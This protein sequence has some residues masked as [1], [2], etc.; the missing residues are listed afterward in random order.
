MR[1]TLPTKIFAPISRAFT[2]WAAMAWADGKLA[3]YL[4]ARWRN[5]SLRAIADDM[6]ADK[7]WRKALKANPLMKGRRKATMTK[8]TT[9]TTTPMAGMP[10]AAMPA[11]T[12]MLTLAAMLSLVA[13]QG[14]GGADDELLLH[15]RAAE[16]ALYGVADSLAAEANKAPERMDDVESTRLVRTPDGRQWLVSISRRADTALPLVS[17]YGDT[18][19][20]YVDNRVTLTV[21]VDGRLVV[22][23]RAWT[24]QSLAAVLDGQPVEPYRLEGMA[25]DDDATAHTPDGR[26]LVLAASLGMPDTDLYVPVR[27]SIDP[28]GHI[29][30]SEGDLLT[31]DKPEHDDTGPTHQGG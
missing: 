7:R 4:Q 18:T 16:V 8:T 17:A 15:R 22:D 23:R 28:Q 29:D 13:C 6:S 25:V 9:T 27:I 3:V 1:Q 19:R 5:L 2:R 26:T 14:K 21:E 30:L 11:L 24:R 31:V 10:M 12:W 20:R